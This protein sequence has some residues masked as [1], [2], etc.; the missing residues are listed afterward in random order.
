MYYYYYY[1]HHHHH[2]HHDSRNQSKIHKSVYITKNKTQISRVLYT[3]CNPMKR[4]LRQHTHYFKYNIQ[5][6]DECS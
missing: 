3:K 1:H 5:L 6:A 2:H 4:I